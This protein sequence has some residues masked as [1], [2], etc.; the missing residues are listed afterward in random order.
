MWKI[1]GRLRFCYSGRL[2]SRERCSTGAGSN[3]D[4]ALIGR[5]RALRLRCLFLYLR[6]IRVQHAELN[7]D[8]RDSE[9]GG[10]FNVTP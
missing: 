3:V 9:D 5:R 8:V 10:R 4:G 7:D 1:F 6:F 2:Y